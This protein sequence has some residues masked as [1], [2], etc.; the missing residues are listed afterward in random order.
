[1]T[2]GVWL[3]W[4]E[5]IRTKEVREI[6]GIYYRHYRDQRLSVGSAARF[7][8]GA[9]IAADELTADWAGILERSRP[10]ANYWVM[11]SPS[12]NNDEWDQRIA[13]NSYLLGKDQ[14]AFVAEQEAALSRPGFQGPWGR[15]PVELRRR[16]DSRLSWY[17]RILAQPEFYLA[18]NHVRYVWLPPGHAL[19]GRADALDRDSGRAV[20]GDVGILVH[21]KVKGKR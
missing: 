4:V 9:V 15:E 3:R 10:L 21:Q 12:V 19:P 16:L 11:L 7:A 20:L 18:Q 14:R 1:M 2:T 5:S 8:P 6:L 13:L 17:D